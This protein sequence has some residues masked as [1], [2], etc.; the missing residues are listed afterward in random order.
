M[1]LNGPQDHDYRSEN[2]VV[3]TSDWLRCPTAL[4]PATPPLQGA[5]N[6]TVQAEGTS[7]EGSVGLARSHQ[8]P[9]NIKDEPA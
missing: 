1:I 8:A 7:L 4:A 6:D 9:E 5:A 2:S 3:R